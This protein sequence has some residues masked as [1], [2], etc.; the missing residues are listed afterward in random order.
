[1]VVM[2]GLSIDTCTLLKLYAKWVESLI[3][4]HFSFAQNNVHFHYCAKWIEAIV[5]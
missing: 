4:Q 3:K 5:G 2:Q 1:M